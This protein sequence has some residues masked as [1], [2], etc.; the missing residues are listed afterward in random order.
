MCFIEAKYILYIITNNIISKIY[1]MKFNINIPYSLL[2]QELVDQKLLT[3]SIAEE[4]KESLV[5]LK[6]PLAQYLVEQKLI[7]PI[8][9]AVATS[10]FF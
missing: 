7:S 10:N 4:I 2:L 3:T 5:V 1:S 6:I 8:K 9:L